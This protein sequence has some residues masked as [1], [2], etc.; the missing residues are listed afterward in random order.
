MEAF[1]GQVWRCASM[2]LP[3]VL[4]W[5]HLARSIIIISII[6]IQP[7]AEDRKT[8]PENPRQQKEAHAPSWKEKSPSTRAKH[9]LCP[10]FLPTLIPE[11]RTC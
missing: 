3:V 4:S 5:E 7:L 6:F 2:L 9:Q 10:A 11:R 8:D 1:L